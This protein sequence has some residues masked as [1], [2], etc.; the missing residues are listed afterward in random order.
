MGRTR[1]PFTIETV[2]FWDP[3]KQTTDFETLSNEAGIV[4]I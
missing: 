3:G 4:T 1:A 2:A